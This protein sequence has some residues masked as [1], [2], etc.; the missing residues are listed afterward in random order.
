MAKLVGIKLPKPKKEKKISTSVLEEKHV[1][2][3]PKWDTERAKKFEKDVFEHNLRA[4]F[5]YYNYFYSQKDLKKHVV[6]WAQK[7]MDLDAKTLSLYIASSAE[8]TPMTVCSLVKAEAVGMPMLKK[9][10][11]YITKSILNAI[12]ET[13]SE[14]AVVEK[15]VAKTV[16]PTIQDRLAEKTSEIIGDLEVEVDNAFLKKPTG[17]PYDIITAKN[18]AHAQ[19]G[20]VR[21]HFQKQIDELSEL[22]AGQDEQLNESYGFLKNSDIKRIG[23]FYVKL[24]ADLDSYSTVKKATK[25][26]KIKRPQNKDKLVAK[27][28]Y[29][30]E[31]K[32]LK[33][34]S[35]PPAD[36]I[37]A[38]ELWV[39][40]TKHKKLG[41]YVADDHSV[42][43]VKGT[44]LTGFSESKSMQKT[45]RKPEEQLAAF[46]KAGKVQLRTFLKDIKAVETKLTG[47]L[48]A[49]TLLL[50]IEK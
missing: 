43:G 15:V 35:V 13:K 50:K 44:T 27:V 4:S 41:K 21:E 30:K 16:A 12:E 22:V 28:Q 24:L 39:Y 32:V 2:S 18:L 19:V 38:Q 20:K 46:M 7:N 29:L 10:K 36:I 23:A 26:L 11:E 48:N 31:S 40:H 8:A 45:L 9:Y 37:G 33:L 14:P 1:G 3:E 34:V 25:K 49:D 42:L 6:A 17:S 5:R 47:R